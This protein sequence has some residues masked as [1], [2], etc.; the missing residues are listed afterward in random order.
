MDISWVEITLTRLLPV[1]SCFADS[2]TELHYGG[3]N[4]KYTIGPPPP[5]FFLPIGG[6][7]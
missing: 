3:E 2:A 7:C 1:T 6:E 5:Q 4:L